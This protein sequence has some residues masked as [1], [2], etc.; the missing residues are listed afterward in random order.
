MF[1]P[2]DEIDELHQELGRYCRRL[3]AAENAEGEWRLCSYVEV[4][5][6]CARYKFQ[7]ARLERELAERQ[8]ALLEGG[9]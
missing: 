6:A 3:H 7:I 1:T 2:E 9:S 5:K 8:A 4:R